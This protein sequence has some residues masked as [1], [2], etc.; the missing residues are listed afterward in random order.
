MEGDIAADAAPLPE[1]MLGGELDSAIHASFVRNQHAR[2]MELVE[3]RLKRSNNRADYALH[4][5]A[6]IRRMEGRIEESLVLLQE[7]IRINPT[8]AD[9]LKQA[10]RSLLLMGEHQGAIEMYD[11][12]LKLGTEDW[13]SWHCKGQCYTFLTQYNLALGCLAEAN[14]ISHREATYIEMGKIY[15]AQEDYDGALEAYAE[16]LEFMPE[17]CKLLTA[18]GLAHLKKGDPGQAFEN[19]GNALAHNPRD[20]DAILAASSIIQTNEDMDVALV[21][22]RVMAANMPHSPQLWNNVGLC[23]LGKDKLVAAV[24]CLKRAL[25][26]AP[27]QWDIHYNLGIVYLNMDQYASAFH[28]FSAAINLK[29]TVCTLYMYL[30]IV[31]SRLD[32][33]ENACTSFKKAVEL[34]PMNPLVR[35]NYALILFNHSSAN[36]EVS[37]QLDEFDRLVGQGGQ[38]VSSALS[39]K[40]A[41]L[42][43][44]LAL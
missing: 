28:A 8:Y 2:C 37:L 31:L 38:E 19:F 32:D 6:L 20:T 11:E 12:A 39:S 17:S 16:G 35:L 23:F 10:A 34:G 9:H 18:S 36:A 24:S 13:E 5:K 33:F 7:A 42:R 43:E 3:D 30:G 22:Y 41:S 40:A 14:S 1:S 27:L 15:C 4:I 25:Y 44:A 29:P 21:K 26:L